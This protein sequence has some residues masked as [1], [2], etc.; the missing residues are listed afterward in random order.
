MPKR[1]AVQAQW[2]NGQA[3]GLPIHPATDRCAIP[4]PLL[5]QIP[6]RPRHPT[7]APPAALLRLAMK[8]VQVR[9][10]GL[11]ALAHVDARRTPKHCSRNGYKAT[12]R[13]R[14]DGPQALFTHFPPRDPAARRAIQ[15]D[16]CAKSES[17][18]MHASRRTNQPQAFTCW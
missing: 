10:I 18:C 5:A 15:S 11:Q 1:W 7:L 3:A 9:A 8:T 4:R 6:G 12:H 2:A 16:H 13:R 17:P 14:E